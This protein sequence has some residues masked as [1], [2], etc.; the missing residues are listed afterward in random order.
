MNSWWDWSGKIKNAQITNIRNAKEHIVIDH[1]HI[2]MIRWYCE[3]LNAKVFEHF[4]ELN[5]LEK[6]SLPKLIIRGNGKKCL[7][8]YLLK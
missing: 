6:H 4:D 7:F 3:Y 5:N 8:L 1:I 2:K